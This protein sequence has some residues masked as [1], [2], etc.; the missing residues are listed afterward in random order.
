MD[1]RGL[2]KKLRMGLTHSD[3]R[4]VD[5]HLT[6]G[7]GC[8]GDEGFGEKG[9]AMNWFKTFF[10]KKRMVIRAYHKEFVL[11]VSYEN[12]ARTSFG[13]IIGIDRIQ[14]TWE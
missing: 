12:P 1:E 7:I 3:R 11:F 6:G 8:N 14:V 2:P 13:D 5:G 9:E 10:R 4:E